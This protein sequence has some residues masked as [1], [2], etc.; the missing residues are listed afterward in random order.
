MHA[1]LVAS[2]LLLAAPAAPG[3]H[4]VISGVVT[5]SK[6]G[7]PLPGALVILQCSCLRGSRETQTNEEG[8]YAFRGLPA[9]TYTVQVLMGNADVVKVLMLPETRPEG[10]P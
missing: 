3:H 9:G 6:T 7:E 2:T 8:F 5:H 1:W 4:G 10:Q